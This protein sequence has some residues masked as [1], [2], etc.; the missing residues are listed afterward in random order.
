MAAI[1]AAITAGSSI[2]GATGALSGGSNSGGG[3][4]SVQSAQPWIEAQPALKALYSNALNWYN[5]GGPQYYPGQTVAGQSPY[6]NQAVAMGAQRASNGSPLIQMADQ[7]NGATMNGAYLNSNPSNPYMQAFA[8]G[9]YT[10]SNPANQYLSGNASGAYLNSN[11]ANS[12]L[13]QTANGEYLKN[14][15]PYLNGMFQNATNQISNQYKNSVAPSIA[16][17]FSA[18]GRFGSGQQYDALAQGA[19]PLQQALA[20]AASNIYGGAYQNERNLQQQAASSLASNYTNAQNL[21][22][23]AAMGIASNYNTGLAMQQ[24]GAQSLANNYNNERGLQQQAIGMA[25]T[26]AGQDYIDL[27]AL[28]GLGQYQQGTQQNIINANQARY[29]FGQNQPLLNLQAPSGLLGGASAYNGQ[30]S[31]TQA[32]QPFNPFQSAIGAGMIG[33]SIGKG[34]F[35]SSNNGNAYGMVDTNMPANGFIY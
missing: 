17:Q 9:S 6:S 7:A 20:D 25:P 29:N 23:Q 32:Q 34:L 2:L 16:S 26:L 21:Q 18:A 28:M 4:S 19:Q 11:P 31:S 27:N 35:G 5:T 10:N 14:D 15:N 33:N 8:N 12:Y 1:P 24:Q 22:Q 3:Q 30:T 13:S